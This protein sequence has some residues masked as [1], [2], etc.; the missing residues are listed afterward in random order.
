MTNLS[1]QEPKGCP[2]G[3]PG[4]KSSYDYLVVGAG[5]NEEL[6]CETYRNGQTCKN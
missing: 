2:A 5:L 4:F 6:V 1:I 3:S